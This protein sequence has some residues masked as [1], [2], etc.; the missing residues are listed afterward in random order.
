ML[1]IS[2]TPIESKK[3]KKNHKKQKKITSFYYKNLN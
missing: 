3:L 2:Y 1:Y